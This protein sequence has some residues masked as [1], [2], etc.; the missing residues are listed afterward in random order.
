[1]ESPKTVCNWKLNLAGNIHLSL[2]NNKKNLKNKNKKVMDVIPWMTVT[3]ANQ[4]A[5]SQ[6]ENIYCCIEIP[7]NS[8]C[9]NLHTNI[10]PTH[11]NHLFCLFLRNKAEMYVLVRQ[12]MYLQDILIHQVEAIQKFS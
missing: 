6:N 8:C 1:M 9:S 5:Q 11:H 7:T 2:I 3:E 10:T 12:V 4:L